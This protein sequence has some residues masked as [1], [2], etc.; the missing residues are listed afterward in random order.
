MAPGTG[1]QAGLGGPVWLP[2]QAGSFASAVQLIVVPSS[3]EIKD[4]DGSSQ[5]KQEPDPTW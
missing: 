4:T 5:I 3:L 2:G 1:R